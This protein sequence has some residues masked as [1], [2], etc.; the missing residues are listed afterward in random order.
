MPEVDETL[1][2]ELHRPKALGSATAR[3]MLAVFMTGAQR[4]TFD[5]ARQRAGTA[6]PVMI[7]SKVSTMTGDKIAEIYTMG[8]MEGANPCCVEENGHVLIGHY[9][10]V[11]IKE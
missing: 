2:Y 5:R 4:R 7:G 1:T 10:F 6:G 8:L 3:N 11:P 9:E